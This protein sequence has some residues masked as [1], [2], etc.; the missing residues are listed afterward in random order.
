VGF[1]YGAMTLLQLYGNA[2]FE[3]E[4]KDRPNIKFR[5]NMNTLWAESGVWSYDFGDGLDNALK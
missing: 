1:F 2:P 3:F 5:G 4:I